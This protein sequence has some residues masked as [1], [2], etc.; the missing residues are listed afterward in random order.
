MYVRKV[1]Q[2]IKTQNR[3]EPK[4]MNFVTNHF[5]KNTLKKCHKDKYNQK[6][7]FLDHVL[8]GL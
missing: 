1:L 5:L 8:R 6:N 3:F 4:K 7:D 2:W